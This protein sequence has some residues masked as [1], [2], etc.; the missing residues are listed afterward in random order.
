MEIKQQ[1]PSWLPKAKLKTRSILNDTA[2]LI[3]SFYTI[4]HCKEIYMQKDDMY[5]NPIVLHF[6]YTNNPEENCI[7]VEINQNIFNG[8]INTEPQNK[9]SL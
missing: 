6:N 7:I 3:H 2:E 5:P 4:H 9:T 1:M 8:K